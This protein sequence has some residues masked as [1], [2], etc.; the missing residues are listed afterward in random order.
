[1]QVC[2][3]ARVPLGLQLAGRSMEDCRGMQPLLLLLN[4]ILAV[5]LPHCVIV[6]D[7]RRLTTAQRARGYN[8]ATHWCSIVAFS[9]ISVLV[10]FVRTRRTLASVALGLAWVCAGLIVQGG[11]VSLVDLVSGNE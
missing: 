1:M 3:A 10:H 4:L 2:V 8:S 9:W 7:R 11:V 5:V 6:F